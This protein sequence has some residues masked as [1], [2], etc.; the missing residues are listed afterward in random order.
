[1]KCGLLEIYEVGNWPSRAQTWV[2]KDVFASRLFCRLFP[3]SSLLGVYQHC[4]FQCTVATNLGNPMPISKYS[5]RPSH[6][7]AR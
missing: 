7:T 1:M 4:A 5:F 6:K 3:A 2:L